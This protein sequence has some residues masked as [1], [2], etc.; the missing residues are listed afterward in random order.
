M[1]TCSTC[2][3]CTPL[4]EGVTGWH[5]VNETDRGYRA[6]LSAVIL[7]AVK[8]LSDADEEVKRDARRFFRSGQYRAICGALDLKPPRLS[9]LLARPRA[10]LV[11]PK[12]RK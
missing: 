12:R 8:D 7:Q 5:I 11:R 1:K 9:D 10:G 4:C 3:T 2:S 6:L